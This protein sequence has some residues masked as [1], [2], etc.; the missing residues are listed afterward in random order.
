MAVNEWEVHLCRDD[1]GV[2]D[3]LFARLDFVPATHDYALYMGRLGW[4]I[5]PRILPARCI[6]GAVAN[7]DDSEPHAIWGIVWT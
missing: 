2:P 3:P 7:W 5:T 1:G 4:T 6:L